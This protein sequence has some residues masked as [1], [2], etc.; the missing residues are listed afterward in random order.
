MTEFDYA[1]YREAARLENR[2]R[3]QRTRDLMRARGW[4][5]YDHRVCPRYL[6]GKRCIAYNR[7]NV[8]CICEEWRERFGGQVL[9]HGRIWKVGTGRNYAVTYEPYLKI[10][11]PKITE[12][13]EFVRQQ[14]F[15]LRATEES[16]HNPPSTVLLE[17][18][19]EPH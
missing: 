8:K 15:R 2:S 7:P 9:D 6:T 14:G 11:D 3:A 18:V 17:V 13:G 5:P 4:K 16:V 10:S 12:F 19:W 1:K